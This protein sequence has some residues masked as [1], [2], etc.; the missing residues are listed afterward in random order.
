MS[1]TNKDEKKI[2]LFPGDTFPFDQKL[3]QYKVFSL[4]KEKKQNYDIKINKN[5]EN[6]KK[7]RRKK[8]QNKIKKKKKKISY[9][10]PLNPSKNK[11]KFKIVIFHKKP[12]DYTT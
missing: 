10:T 3:L 6:D 11:N 8:K 7:K 5:Y 4:K 12:P 9:F 2:I 1:E